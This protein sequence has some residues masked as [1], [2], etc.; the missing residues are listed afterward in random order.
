MLVSNAEYLKFV[1]DGGYTESG[2][3]WWSDEGW[4]YV[5]DM[6][7]KGPRFWIG[8]T[9]YRMM[10]EVIP[11][12]WNYPV[13]VNN[14]EAEAFCNWKSD[15]LGGGKKVRLISHEESV[16]M[17]LNATHETYNHNLNKFASPTPVNLY[18]GIIDGQQV[19]DL[20]GNVWRHSVSLLTIMDGFKI[21]PFYDDFTIP[22]IDGHHNH[23]LGGSWISLGNCANVNARYGFRRHFYQFAG[24]RYVCSS[25]KY[26]D[27]V[28]KIYNSALFG[29]MITEHFKDFVEEVDVPETPVRNWPA[30]LGQI[31]A[32]VIKTDPLLKEKERIKVMVAHGSV[33]RTTLE[34]LRNCSGLDV[35]HT[36]RTA[37][38]IQVL[39]SLLNDS[40][41]QWLQLTEGMLESPM[42]YCLSPDESHGRLLSSKGNTIHYWQADYKNIRP[43]LDHFDVIVVDFRYE[44]ASEHLLHIV[45]RLNPEG[46][47]ILASIDD[48]SNNN[49][50]PKNA[51]RA[52]GNNFTRETFFGLE[53][54]RFAHVVQSNKNIFEYAI[55]NL[56]IWRKRSS[57][58]ED[59][60][61]SSQLTTIIEIDKRNCPDQFVTPYAT[62]YTQKCLWLDNFPKKMAEIC[63][64]ACRKYNVPMNLGNHDDHF[65]LSLN[66]E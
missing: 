21:D 63:V 16:L 33:G 46:L 20:S 34:L 15:R 39:E 11:M 26:H 37:N 59:E 22:T 12:P 47:L 17:R 3:R 61:S 31:S 50:G 66:R 45:E 54:E 49:G 64:A 19:F 30:L 57:D 48:V 65:N 32:E 6:N 10:L 24:I 7:V 41:V 9:H 25:N 4:K 58:S 2:R 27:K 13:E 35:Y 38:L 18:G 52:L 62:H 8:K 42:D 43:V 29:K 23:I 36:D 1:N 14:L 51:V 55:S 28:P 5:M 40:K 44:N 53:D 56:S 60:R